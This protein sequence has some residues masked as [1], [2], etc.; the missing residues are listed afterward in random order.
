VP[1]CV[2]R[3]ELSGLERL[4]QLDRHVGRPLDDV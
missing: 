2:D 4:Q 1:Y 3:G